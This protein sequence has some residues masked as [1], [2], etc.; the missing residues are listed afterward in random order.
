VL[1]W[2][3]LVHRVAAPLARAR[4]RP[5]ALSV[6]GGVLAGLAVVPALYA[7]PLP[8]LAAVLLLLG[9]FVDG[10]DGAVAVLRR[11]V[12]QFG[13]VLDSV[14]DRFADVAAASAIVL[15]GGRAWFGVAAVGS[16]VLLEYTR[17]RAAAVG[18]A[19]IGVVTV[20][21][22]PIRVAVAAVALVVVSA[23][24]RWLVGPAADG[25]LL[26]LAALGLAGFLQFAVAFARGTRRNRR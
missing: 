9:A 20:G 22:R 23:V 1:G 8:V 15:A 18:F 16:V 12:T 2:L 6:L 4:V 19:E 26:L 13:G 10:L 7:R 14:V 11:R 17:A 3:R 21:E 24:P 5:S 25:A